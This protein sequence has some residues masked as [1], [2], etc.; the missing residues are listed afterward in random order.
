MNIHVSSPG[1]KFS[2]SYNLLWTDPQPINHSA[3]NHQNISIKQ[4]TA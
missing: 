2:R 4:N 3:V 1:N